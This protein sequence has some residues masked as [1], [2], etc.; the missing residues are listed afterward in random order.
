MTLVPLLMGWG[1]HQT[2]SL[3]QPA[4]GKNHDYKHNINMIKNAHV[5]FLQN[6]LFYNMFFVIV[7]PFSWVFLL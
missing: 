2:Y 4:T 1:R 3:H 7:I 5:N 6:R